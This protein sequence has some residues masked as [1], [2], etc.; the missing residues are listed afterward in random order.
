MVPRTSGAGADVGATLG[1]GNGVHV[2]GV[3]RVGGWFFV[4][5]ADGEVSVRATLDGPGVQAL[6][7]K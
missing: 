6:R 1:V 2:A 3:S 4:G 7:T 5:A